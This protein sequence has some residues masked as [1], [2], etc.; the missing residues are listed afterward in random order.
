MAERP[1]ALDFAGATLEVIVHI[2]FHMKKYLLVF[3]LCFFVLV[4]SV[5][6]QEAVPGKLLIKFKDQTSIRKDSEISFT[7]PFIN[8]KVT[9]REEGMVRE[10]MRAIQELRK[11][12]GL[13]VSDVPILRIETDA[14]GKEL[15]EKNKIVISKTAFLKDIEFVAVSSGPISVE[16]LSFKLEI[17]K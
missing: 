10:L 2:R 16:H 8:Q 11:K 3:G 5:S 7:V 14:G 13:T 6:A 1:I 12:S 17:V 9:L 15:I 4:D